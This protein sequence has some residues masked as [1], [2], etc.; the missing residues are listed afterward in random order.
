MRTLETVI[1]YCDAELL[2]HFEIEGKYTAA[3][4]E[5]PADCPEVESTKIF[6][7]DVEISGIFLEAQWEDIYQLLN[8]KLEL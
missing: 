4:Y 3:T 7:G 6:A 5:V 8:N 2:I 1:K